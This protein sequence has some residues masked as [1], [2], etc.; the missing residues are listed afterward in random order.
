MKTFND[1]ISDINNKLANGPYWSAGVT[2]KRGNPLPLDAFSVFDA[3]SAAQAYVSGTGAYE[4]SPVSFE[5]QVIVVPNETGDLTQY[6]IKNGGLEPIGT[7][8]WDTLSA[9][10]AAISSTTIPVGTMAI[11]PNEKG[12]LALFMVVPNGETKTVKPVGTEVVADNK[13]LSVDA[14]GVIGLVGA[15]DVSLSGTWEPKFKDGEFKWVDTTQTPDSNDLLDDIITLRRDLSNEISAR[16]DADS[17]LSGTIDEVSSDLYKLSGEVSSI[18]VDLLEVINDVSGN[19][20][21]LSGEVSSISTDFDGR[22]DTLETDVSGLK[23]ISTTHAGKITEIQRELSTLIGSAFKF[24]GSFTSL[25]VAEKNRKNGDVVIVENIEY[26]WVQADDDPNGQFE[27]LGENGDIITREE[28]N[29]ALTTHTTTVNKAAKDAEDAKTAA[30]AAQAEATAAK[31]AALSAAQEATELKTSFD[32]AVETA[33]TEAIATTTAEAK[34]AKTAAEAAQAA[35]E[36]A[37]QEAAELKTSFDN[38]VETAVTEAVTEATAEAKDAKTAAEAAAQEAAELKTSFDNAVET[39]V[40]EAVTEAT[41]EA[42][43]A[44]T[45]AEAAAQEATAAKMAAEAAQ[46]E[47][48]DAAK[49]ASAIQTQVQTDLNTINGTIGDIQAELDEK[50]DNINGDLGTQMAEISDNV[51]SVASALTEFIDTVST[52]YQEKITVENGLSINNN[53]NTIGINLSALSSSTISIS[54]TTLNVDISKIKV[55]IDLTSYALSN[56]VTTLVSRVSGE[57]LASA[58]A[59]TDAQITGISSTISTT[60]LSA[61]EFSTY[62]T[63]ANTRLTNIENNVSTLSNTTIPGLTTR[64]DQLTST[65]N[66]HEGRITANTT[67]ISTLKTSLNGLSNEVS[68]I[69]ADHE[70]RLDTLSAIVDGLTNATRFIGVA[71]D[72]SDI[73][74]PNAQKIKIKG[75]EH[76]ISSGDIVIHGDAEYIAVHAGILDKEGDFFEWVQLGDESVCAETLDLVEELSDKFEAHVTTCEAADA[77]LTKDLADEISARIDADTEL[78]TAISALSDAFEAHVI[79]CED[80]DAKLTKDLADEISARV[81]DVEE[82]HTELSAHDSRIQE[83]EDTLAGILILNGGNAFGW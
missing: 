36:A 28:L 41:A 50:L 69:S 56:D 43:A 74:N 52:D 65:V 48:Q 31:D 80:A 9:F 49:T 61:S 71:D 13:T 15:A 5:G 53:T 60:Y 55:D 39:A 29:S 72:L 17:F 35:A 23:E 8:K 81:A 62:Q 64:I 26:V 76:T 82:I 24:C 7:Q 16:K 18:S 68:G 63:S 30:E 21:G 47:A 6:M 79:S 77:K 1:L 22:L 75:K 40:T 27:Q 3:L 10:E 67:A 14:N 20:T 51:I 38:A 59:Y 83:V 78:S 57:T 37:A 42:T 66:D 19:L 32:N 2:F 54:G 45:A 70:C 12:E 46:A 44:K 33:I 11:A 58:S 34:D 73:T 25:S 4:A